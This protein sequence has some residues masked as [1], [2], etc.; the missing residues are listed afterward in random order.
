M[1]AIQRYLHG[2]CALTFCPSPST[3]R[4]LSDRGFDNLRIWS[5]GADT[6]LF[7]PAKRDPALRSQWAR[8]I[9]PSPPSA[10]DAP[11][12]TDLPADHEL[13]LLFVGRIAWEKNLRGASPLI[14]DPTDDAVL[15]EAFRGLEAA[16]RAA[17]PDSTTRIR[18]VF[19][20]DGPARA[21]IAALCASHGLRTLFM[22]HREGA[23]LA[24]CYASAD[25]FAFPSCA[26]ARRRPR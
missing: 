10:D 8:N 18:L 2:R 19:V 15:V 5:R 14:T 24:R 16:Y 21:D 13:V 17:L 4:M 20:G 26:C 12:P 9:A 6:V 25:V 3:A 1:W 11:P 7:N 23:D 22:G